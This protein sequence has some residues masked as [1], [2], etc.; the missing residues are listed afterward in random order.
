M[1]EKWDWCLKR[2]NSEEEQEGS[3]DMVLFSPRWVF[4]SPR[5]NA[6]AKTQLNKTL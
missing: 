5:V 6:E 4:H 1:R 3:S 2:C